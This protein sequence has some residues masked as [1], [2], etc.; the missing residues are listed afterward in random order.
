MKDLPKDFN[1]IRTQNYIIHLSTE[2]TNRIYRGSQLSDA[3]CEFFGNWFAGLAKENGADV[4]G[5]AL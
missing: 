4:C 5:R 1:I 3:I 2:D